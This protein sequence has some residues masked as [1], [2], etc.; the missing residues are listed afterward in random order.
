MTPFRVGANKL[1]NGE[2][3]FDLRKEYHHVINRLVEWEA[4]LGKFQEQLRLRDEKIALLEE[5]VAQLS[6]EIQ[7]EKKKES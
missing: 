5:R 2:A 3:V 7:N 4:V 6:L 1:D